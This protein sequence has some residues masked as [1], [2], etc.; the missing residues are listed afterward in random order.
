MAEANLVS[1]LNC[2]LRPMLLTVKGL[3]ASN[4]DTEALRRCEGCGAYWIYRYHEYVTFDA[5]DD[6]TVWYSLLSPE[7]GE[8]VLEGEERPDLTFIRD[9]P[10]FMEDRQGVK[11]VPGSPYPGG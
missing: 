11:Q 3:S 4:H 8:R 5:E 1:Y 2:C 6:W 10:S 9:R 7:E